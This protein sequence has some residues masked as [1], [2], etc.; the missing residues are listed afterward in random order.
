[1]VSNAKRSL[2]V[3]AILACSALSSDISAPA[4]LSAAPTAGITTLAQPSRRATATAFRP[5][6][7]PPP[8]RIAEAGS[9]PWLM[10]ISSIAPTIFSV[11]SAR[12]AAAASSISRPS[13]SAT[14]PASALRAASTSRRIAPP[15]KNAGSI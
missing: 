2:V 10:V 9:I 12:V 7:P 13:S 3:N 15:R 6:A 11:A 1:M 4:A 5:A 8:I 14:W